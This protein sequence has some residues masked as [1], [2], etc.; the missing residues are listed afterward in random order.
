MKQQGDGST[1]IPFFMMRAASDIQNEN[2]DIRRWQ[3]MEAYPFL[4]MKRMS[5]LRTA[6][7]FLRRV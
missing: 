5:V 3:C 4:R 2:D 1:A 6:Y 7:P